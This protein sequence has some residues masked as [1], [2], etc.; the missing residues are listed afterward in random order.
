MADVDGIGDVDSCGPAACRG[1]GATLRAARLDPIR[2]VY[3]SYPGSG[4]FAASGLAYEIAPDQLPA[5]LHKNA[6]TR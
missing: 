2:I 5:P 4:S 3:T 6:R 1:T